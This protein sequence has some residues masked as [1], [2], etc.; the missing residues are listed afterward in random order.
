MNMITPPKKHWQMKVFPLF[1]LLGWTL[2]AVSLIIGSFVLAS[3]AANYWGN[4]AKAVRDAAE[5][6]SLLIGQLQT[7]TVIPRWL[8][9]LT[10]LGVASFM[11]GIALE[12]SSIPAALKKR[13]IVL[14]ATFPL[15]VKLNQEQ[16]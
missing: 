11:V 10:F 2:I 9:P 4:N 6:G 13:A 3:T 14:R 5:T 8:E 12:F 7:L 16:K 1:T 15:S